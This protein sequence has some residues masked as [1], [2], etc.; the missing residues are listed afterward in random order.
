MGAGDE[1]AGFCW[2]DLTERGHLEYLGVDGSIILK[3]IFRKWD[4]EA[5]TGL[6][7]D[8]GRL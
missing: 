2:G 6:G 8:G 1:H 5:R 7:R 3:L 4:G